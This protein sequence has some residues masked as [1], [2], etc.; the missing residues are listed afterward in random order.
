LK[1]RHHGWPPLSLALVWLV[2]GC[3]PV[4]QSGSSPDRS[5]IDD[6]QHSIVLITLSG[7][8]PD[9]VGALGAEEL[10]T[11]FI[12]ALAAE[13]DWVGTSVVASSAPVA[14]LASLMTGLSP[15]HH[16]ALGHSRG[17]LREELLSLAQALR[18]GGYSTFARIPLVYDLGR[19]GLLQGFDQIADAEP[20]DKTVAFLRGMSNAPALYWL[21]LREANVTFER[22]DAAIPRLGAKAVDLPAK[23]I[24]PELWPYADPQKSLPEPL[25]SAARELFQHE[26]AWADHQVGQLLQAVR[27][28]GHWERSWIIVTATQGMEFG[29]H[30][31]ILFSQNLG[32]ESIEVPLVIKAPLS[33][34]DSL[35]AP[36]DFAVGQTR[37]WST[38]VEA[39]GGTTA[40]AHAPS[41]FQSTTLPIVSELYMRNGVSLFSLV[42]RD[43]QVVQ[44][45]RFASEEPEFY[46]AQLAASG[47]HPELSEP[48]AATLG[49]LQN[50]FDNTRPFSGLFRGNS[51]S[52][53][54][55]WTLDGVEPFEDPELQATMSRALR[56]KVRALA[57]SE[58]TPTE[59]SALSGS[60]R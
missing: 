29:E 24:A 27:D 17:R 49:R 9:S 18:L 42:D 58:R 60:A 46:L 3:S 34:R 14:S 25:S 13:A 26:V 50:A 2:V 11:P 15:W 4:S 8:R 48:A 1:Q 33:R 55:R 47:G 41:L 12:D 19:F 44:A 37:L 22:R 6:Q 51:D 43:I 45:S 56:R 54:E 7:L 31:Q 28:S 30:G 35:R 52:T 32:R 40:P 10:K 21:H 23:I 53:L 20:M 5:H 57:G 36:S 38:L 59:E 16:Q 39:G